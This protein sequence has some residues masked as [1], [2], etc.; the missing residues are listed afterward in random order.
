MHENEY[1]QRGKQNVLVISK[2]EKTQR[3]LISY[4]SQHHSCGDTP[5][6][7]TYPQA[8]TYVPR[9]LLN[10]QFTTTGGWGGRRKWIGG[11]VAIVLI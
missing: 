4:Y 6:R 3:E 2:N 5:E 11:S 1:K 8:S 9:R 7:L 10:Y